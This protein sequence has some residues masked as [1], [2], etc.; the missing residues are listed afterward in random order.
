MEEKTLS[1]TQ[2]SRMVL[3]PS[4]QEPTIHSADLWG[5]RSSL[6]NGPVYNLAEMSTICDALIGPLA[7]EIH[8]FDDPDHIMSLACSRAGKS[9]SFSFGSL[10]HDICA[11]VVP[12]TIASET[13]RQI[14]HK[15]VVE[16][17][18]KIRSLHG[19]G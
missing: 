15:Y 18:A 5:G 14:V 13:K 2:K 3:F 8:S 4:K 19:A 17:R 6:D 10:L 11:K 16:H 1:K 7:R 9:D 12:L